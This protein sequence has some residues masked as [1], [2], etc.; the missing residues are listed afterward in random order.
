[1]SPD[2]LQQALWDFL[3]TSEDALIKNVGL[4]QS[5]LVPVWYNYTLKNSKALFTFIN[6]PAVRQLYFEVTYDEDEKV[7]YID[8]YQK[9]HHEE[10]PV[11]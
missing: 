3:M 5:S 6:S 1:M 11:S 8:S 9:V 7:V 10:V 2:K 4:V